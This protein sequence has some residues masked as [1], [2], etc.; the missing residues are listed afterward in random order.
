M[1]SIIVPAH[2]EASTIQRCLS[3]MG[4]R[5]CK[6][7]EVVVVCNG[8]TD[9]TAE[10]ARQ[11]SGTVK[12]IET[13]I[14][15]KVNALNLGEE[16]VQSFPRLYVDA[17]VQIS[18]D[19]ILRIVEALE[20]HGT[21]AAAPRIRLDLRGCGWSVR[22]FYAID[23]QLPSHALGLGG[24]GVYALSE[25]GRQRFGVFPNIICDDGFVRSLFSSGERIS[26]P[27]SHSVVTPPK[28][29][30]GLITIKTRSHLGSYELYRR[31]PELK[32][33]TRSGNGSALLRKIPCVMVWPQLAAYA[34]VKTVAKWRARRRLRQ[35]NLLWERDET[36]R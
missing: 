28:T 3:V 25:E 15:S 18:R 30:G 24:S 9:N 22:A 12:V 8:C 32:S 23:C 16:V 1:P 35:E 31:Y 10:L 29:L 26:V 33:N 34:F 19:S 36:S 6:E 20:C 7:F 17:D 11:F 21:L 5:L 27:G 14:S 13:T 4:E 2:N